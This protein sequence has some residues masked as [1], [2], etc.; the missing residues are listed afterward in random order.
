MVHIKY[1]ATV[2][3]KRK[4]ELPNVKRRRIPGIILCAISPICVLTGAS[5]AGEIGLII[6]IL[7]A[8]S[9]FLSGIYQLTG[10]Y[11]TQ[12]PY[13]NEKVYIKKN[14]EKVKCK[15]CKQVAIMCEECGAGS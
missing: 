10:I 5:V 14:T 8:V 6:G 3:K 1:L 15:Y 12:C 2:D 11:E 13:C 9:F 4:I 7:F